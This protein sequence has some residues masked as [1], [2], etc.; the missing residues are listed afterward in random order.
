MRARYAA[1]PYAAAVLPETFDPDTLRTVALVGIGAL[2]LLAFLVVRLVQK[3]VLRVILLGVV[4]GL[5]AYLW[6]QRAE[7]EDCVPDCSC[8]FAGFEVDVPG[9]TPD[10]TPEVEPA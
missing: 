6:G 5:G 1:P 2:A 7:L 3:M 4:V 10:G 9:C 8:T